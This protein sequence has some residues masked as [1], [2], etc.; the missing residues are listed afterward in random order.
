MLSTSLFVNILQVVIHF[1]VAS[2]LG[3]AQFGVIKIL[4]MIQE[5]SKYGNL[6]FTSVAAREIPYHRGRQDEE[7]EKLTRNVAYSSEIILTLVLT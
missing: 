2:F 5:M 7:K 1:V 4:E 6:G 3:P